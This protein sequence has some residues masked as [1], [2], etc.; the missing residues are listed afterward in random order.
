M[1]ASEFV[2]AWWLQ[3]AHLQTLWGKLFRK[4][5]AAPTTREAWTAP[6]GEIVEVHRLKSPGSKSRL[7]LLHGLE[8]SVRSHYAQGLLWQAQ[9]RGW[10][11]DLLIFRTCGAAESTRPRMYHSGETTD[12]GWV[13]DRIIA[14]NS[15]TSIGLVG[16]SLGGNVLLK[17]LGERGPDLADQVCAAAAISVPFDLEQSS[18]HINRGFSKVYQWHFMRTLRRKARAKLQQFPQL[19]ELSRVEAAETMYDY[20]NVMTAPVHGFRDASDY[21]TQSSSIHWIN[22]IAIPTLLLSAADDPFLPAEALD[23]VRVLAGENPNLVVEFHPHGGHVGFIGGSN[24]VQPVYYAEQRAAD[25]VSSF[26]A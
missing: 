19:A 20:D 3:G 4:L 7:V 21:Y 5:P 26:I 10:N 13:V 22:S 15:S 17:Y 12:L 25:F 9:K 16:V 23:R 1:S 11:A 8:G 18:R 2:P 24:P 6:D 14:E